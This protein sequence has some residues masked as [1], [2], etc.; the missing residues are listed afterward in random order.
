MNIDL[1][2]LSI[3]LGRAGKYGTLSVAVTEFSPA[4]NNYL[5]TYGLRQCLNDA[6]ADK[7]DEDGNELPADQIIAKAR[8]RL[9]NLYAGE[10][11]AQREAS[12][13]ADPVEAEAWKMAKAAMT[14]AYKTI[15][16]W[17]Q[18]EKG[19]KDRFAAVVA[20][21]RAERKLPELS[22]ADAVKDAIEKFLAAPANAHIR[23]SAER[24]VAERAKS[25]GAVDLDELGI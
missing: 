24:I 19:T 25:A 8:K 13:P 22:P 15:G 4:V 16:A 9:D 14:D 1:A 12:E 6:M 7:K 5:Y 18:V 10:L 23:E 11:R 2:T 3:P 20:M 21:R 17:A